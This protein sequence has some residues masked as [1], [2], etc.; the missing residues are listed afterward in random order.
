MICCVVRGKLFASEE[1][2]FKSLAK[3]ATDGIREASIAISAKSQCEKKPF[4]SIFSGQVMSDVSKNYS[5]KSFP[6]LYLVNYG[7]YQKFLWQLQNLKMFGQIS[8]NFAIFVQFLRV[9]RKKAKNFWAQKMPWIYRSQK[10]KPFLEKL[11]KCKKSDWTKITSK[12]HALQK[13]SR[14]CMF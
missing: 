13:T 7:F 9:Y 4:G 6:Q 1:P 14:L 10:I 3:V 2:L 5:N 11:T 8:L 12:L